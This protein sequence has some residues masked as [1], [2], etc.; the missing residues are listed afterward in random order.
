[1]S[2]IGL[3]LENNCFDLKVENGD[4]VA[5]NGLET[6]VSISLFTER[7]VSDEELPDL[8]YNKRGWWGDV[9]PEQDQ[10]Q[11]GSRLWTIDRSKVLTETLRRSEELCKE[12]LIWMQEDGIA[13]EIKI[14]SIYNENNNMITT[15]QIT[16]PDEQTERFS[17]LWD[18]QELRRV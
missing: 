2:D 9:F 12:S 11:I 8:E 4:L 3:I 6:A 15:I 5:D 1:M 18:E 14:E 13:D 10:D 7:R 16:R 17:V